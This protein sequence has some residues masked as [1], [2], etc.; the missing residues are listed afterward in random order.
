MR[1]EIQVVNANEY[2]R[3]TGRR[4]FVALPQE[5]IDRLYASLEVLAAHQNEV[6]GDY[7][8]IQLG[9]FVV[10]HHNY[11]W[12]INR[13][14][15]SNSISLGFFSHLSANSNNHL[16]LDDSIR[17]ETRRVFEENVRLKTTYDVRLAGLIY[18]EADVFGKTHLGIT[19]ICRLRQQNQAEPMNE[20]FEMSIMGNG[21]LLQRRDQF[22]NWSK[23]LIENINAM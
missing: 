20:E 11:S 21:E 15:K 8:S 5:E 17:T 18:D 10:A 22:D 4:P 1:S 6:E 12:L 14:V 3:V 16:F 2:G 19:C 13:N 7:G 9:L 23:I